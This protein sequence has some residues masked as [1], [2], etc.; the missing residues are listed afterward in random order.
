MLHGTR[1]AISHNVNKWLFVYCQQTACLNWTWAWSGR[2]FWNSAHINTHSHTDTHISPRRLTRTVLRPHLKTL[3]GVDG[4]WPETET[5]LR[6]VSVCV[7]VCV[8]KSHP[9]LLNLYANAGG[10][11]GV[12]GLQSKFQLPEF[13]RKLLF[14]CLCICRPNWRE[15]TLK[16]AC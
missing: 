8:S 12:G 7:C 11:E 14:N 1:P 16:I 6:C 5:A 15:S 13:K 9:G 2:R 10:L 3:W 4:F